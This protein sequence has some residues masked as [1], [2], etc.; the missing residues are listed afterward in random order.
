MGWTL[1]QEENEKI[2]E[3]QKIRGPWFH[4]QYWEWNMITVP[5]LEMHAYYFFLIM[6]G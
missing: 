2:K 1:E 5:T 3:K 4:S 6:E